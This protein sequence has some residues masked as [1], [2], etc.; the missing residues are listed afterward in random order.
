MA[1]KVAQW[2]AEIMRQ[3][4]RTVLLQTL[5]HLWREHL[6]MLE[7]LRNVVGL[8]GYAQR[9]PLNEY[10][11]EAYNLFEAMSQNLREAVTA[12][13]MRIEVVEQAPELPT[14]LPYME[15]HHVNPYSGEDEITIEHPSLQ[16]ALVGAGN[17]T[18]GAPERNPSDPT[19]WGKV[20]RNEVCPCGSGKKFKHC[21]GRFG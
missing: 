8:R 5:D 10:K 7:H 19:S 16:P 1:T 14:S 9:D 2:G 3:I 18:A 4:E 12:Q 6:V 11:A 13:M 17:G 21:H 20:G 15:A